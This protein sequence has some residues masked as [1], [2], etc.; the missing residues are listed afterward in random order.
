VCC[1][2]RA[3]LHEQ[4]FAC[5]ERYS[6]RSTQHTALTVVKRAAAFALL[7]AGCASAQ[8]FRLD[9][10]AIVDIDAGVV[11]RDMTIEVRGDRIVDV[12][13][14]TGTAAGAPERYVLPGLAD[15]H[16]HV[17]DAKD[18]DI[19]RNLFPL[20]IA[21]GV[22]TVRDM[23]GDLHE[24]DALR[25]DIRRGALIG[26]DLLRA[27]PFLDG[28]KPVS[29]N[30]LI[31][32]SAAGARDAVARLAAAGVDFIKIH[33]GISAEAFRA[34]VAEAERHGLPVAV[35]LGPVSVADAV[36]AGVRSVE[37]TETLLTNPPVRPPS[38]GDPMKDA[39]AILDEYAGHA[40]KALAAEFRQHDACLVPTLVEYFNFAREGSPEQLNDPSQTL[41]AP[42]LRRFW[43]EYF[44]LAKTYSPERAALRRRA[45]DAFVA[46]VGRMHAENVCVLAGTDVGARGVVPGVA[47]HE[48]LAFLVQ[49]GFTP[50]EAL[51]ASVDGPRRFFRRG[52]AAR[53]VAGAPATFVI[54]TANPLDRIENARRID[55]VMLRGRYLDRGA[56]D[57]LVV[58]GASRTGSSVHGP[59]A[60]FGSRIP[61]TNHCIH[62]TSC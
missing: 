46:I 44:P 51:R 18:D 2:L 28:P 24:L 20:F 60:M 40:G 56:L 16:V 36:R 32:T 45:F 34:A 22:T 13:K 42:S 4:S 23:G 19:R 47:L 54:V 1:V 30:R 55:A 37:H 5:A 59:S 61:R 50:A 27:G 25:S 29:A 10:V 9:H 12:R 21:N 31:V 17:T 8:S 15:M 33:N 41:V 6:A 57:R 7:L 38:T 48:E 3:P 39:A 49:A 26:P 11:R 14:S 58:T 53:I 43:D 35:H 62:A 52:D